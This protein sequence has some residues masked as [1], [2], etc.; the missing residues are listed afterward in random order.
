MNEFSDRRASRPLLSMQK[1]QI[2]LKCDRTVASTLFKNGVIDK[3]NLTLYS[4]IFFVLRS[5][6]LNWNF[7]IMSKIA[8]IFT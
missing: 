3:I 2:A 8:Y 5:E 6:L 1:T 4:S 7:I